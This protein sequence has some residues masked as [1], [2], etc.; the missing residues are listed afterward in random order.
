[1]SKRVL[2]TLGS[3]ATAAVLIAA[4][5]VASAGLSESQ[6]NANAEGLQNQPNQQVSCYDTTALVN[7]LN[8]AHQ[9]DANNVQ[10]VLDLLNSVTTKQAVKAGETVPNGTNGSV[11]YWTTADVGED[12]FVTS[13]PN[14]V[15]VAL[16]GGGAG[17][18]LMFYDSNVTVPE[19]GYFLSDLCAR[20]NPTAELTY[21]PGY[22]A[23]A[24]PIGPTA[25]CVD[26]DELV[27]RLNAQHAAN[28][29]DPSVVFE[30]LESL[31]VGDP[32]EEGDSVKAAQDSSVIWTQADIDERFFERTTPTG[33]IVAYFGGSTTILGLY[34]G[35]WTTGFG[36]MVAPMCD[37]VNPERE[38]DYWAIQD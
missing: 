1:M 30:W 11:I 22:T 13:D 12:K 28:E 26:P 16:M 5:I 34:D 24:G 38:L 7:K 9:T 17:T 15:V 2:Y 23:P 31:G 33:T 35:E 21:W 29:N 18:V 4:L 14:G 8:S 37:R 32:I 6:S 3:L 20:I 25:E 19:D 27:Q 10:P 36:G